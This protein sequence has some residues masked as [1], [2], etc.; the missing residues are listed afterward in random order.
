MEYL[1]TQSGMTF[2]PMS[3]HDLASEI[4]EGFSEEVELTE[5]GAVN[6]DDAPVA[7]PPDSDSEDEV[8]ITGA[9]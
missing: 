4:D 5:S 8:S 6:I 9:V 3:E 2:Q 7:I 1:Y